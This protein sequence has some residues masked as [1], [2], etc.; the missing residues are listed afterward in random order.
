MILIKPWLEA[1]KEAYPIRKLVFIDG[2][3]IPE[4]MELDEFDPIAEHA[5]AY[6]EGNCIGTARLIALPG[7]EGR[8]GRMAVL[9][10]FRKQGIGKQLLRALLER[11]KSQGLIR[12]TLHAQLSAIPFYEQ[13]GFI[14]QGDI[15]DEA[16]IAHRDMILLI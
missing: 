7:Q 15:Y 5:L 10:A 16:G 14:A 1:E 4:A 9:P 3:G 13:F 12:L 11:S 8:I 6:Q 2:Q